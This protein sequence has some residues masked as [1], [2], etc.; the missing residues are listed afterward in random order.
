MNAILHE[1]VESTIHQAFSI[2]LLKFKALLQKLLNCRHTATLSV[3]LG[4]R[5]WYHK[6]CKGFLPNFHIS[7]LFALYHHMELTCKD[8]LGQ[9]LS[10]SRRHSQQTGIPS[11]LPSMLG[12]NARY[13]KYQCVCVCLCFVRAIFA[14]CFWRSSTTFFPKLIL[15]GLLFSSRLKLQYMRYKNASVKNSP[16]T[17]LLM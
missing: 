3:C 9:L 17:K 7:T 10:R 2:Q 4:R 15:E 6:V 5:H 12:M 8:L 1:E 14:N 16:C 11:R 13:H